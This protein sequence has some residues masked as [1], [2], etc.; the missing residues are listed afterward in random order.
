[1]SNPCTK[2]GELGRLEQCIDLLT[3]EIFGNGQKGLIKTIPRLE[4]KIDSMI[5]TQ[6]GMLTTISALVKFQIGTTSVDDFKKNARDYSLRKTAIIISAI[7]SFG[8][9]ASSLILRLVN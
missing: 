7:L 4:D 5:L 9:V 6:S 8:A 3:K 2:E 1:M